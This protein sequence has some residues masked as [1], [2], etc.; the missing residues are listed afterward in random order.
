MLFYAGVILSVSEIW[1]QC[2][3]HLVLVPAGKCQSGVW[4]F[5]FQLCSTPMY[6]C[7]ALLPALRKNKLRLVGVIDTYLATYGLLGG[8]FAFFDTSGFTELGYLPIS[9]H[10]YLWHFLLI[11]AGLAAGAAL[12]LEDRSVFPG[13]TALF[14]GNCLIAQVLNL[15][16]GRYG[17][18][19]M[20]YINPKLVMAQKVFKDI[21]LYTGNDAG[22]LVYVLTIILGAAVLYL[23]WLCLGIRKRS[24]TPGP[25]QP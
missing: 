22:I 19:N 4:Y 8:I 17:T 13:A 24:G 5:P 12:L 2:V 23:L 1:K 15:V 6:A 25:G 11:A 16:L 9:V 7:L 10:S 18:I 21:A 20:F 3:I 14:L